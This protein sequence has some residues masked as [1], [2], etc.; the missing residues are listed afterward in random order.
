MIRHPTRP[1]IILLLAIIPTIL[2]CGCCHQIKVFDDLESQ[3]RSAL[4]TLCR[5][6]SHLESTR[7]Y[8]QLQTNKLYCGG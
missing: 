5:S 2:G 1:L 7:C 8:G 4:A 6:L 3:P